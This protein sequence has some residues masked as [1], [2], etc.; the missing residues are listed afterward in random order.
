MTKQVTSRPANKVATASRQPTALAKPNADNRSKIVSTAS[1]VRERL[2]T[3]PL[4]S[5]QNQPLER[6]GF[7]LSPAYHDGVP[8]EEFSR[9]NT[10]VATALKAALLRLDSGWG[11]ATETSKSK[12]GA[13]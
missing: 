8:N 5:N 13:P 7:F 4:W 1:S 9:A 10:D 11:A 2:K 3:S 12:E 6:S